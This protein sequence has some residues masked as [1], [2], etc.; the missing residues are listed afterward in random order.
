MNKNPFFLF[1]KTILITGASS[2]IGRSTA[3]ECSKMGASCCILVGRNLNALHETAHMMDKDCQCVIKTCE[4][5]DPSEIDR[6]IL[7]IPVVDGVVCNA[8]INKMRPLQF[9]NEKDIDAIFMVNCFSPM[10]LIKQLVKKKKLANPSSVVF[11]A[12]ISGYSNVSVGNG[13]YGASKSALSAFMKYAALELASKGIR[14]NAVHPG[15]VET[16]LIHN[17]VT[18]EEDIKKDLLK[19]PLGRYSRPEEIAYSIIYLLSD[20]SA[21][22]TGSDLVIDGGR[23]LI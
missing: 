5:S 10:L 21:C 20:A 13:V 8:G 12:S 16:P 2:G 3:V 4:L 1:G 11:T 17:G 14:C 23:S 18:D 15:R 19:Y 22:V 7:D 6:L 9:Y